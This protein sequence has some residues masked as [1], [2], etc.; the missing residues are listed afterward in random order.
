MSS[1]PFTTCVGATTSAT[2][3]GFPR[4]DVAGQRIRTTAVRGV[5]RTRAAHPTCRFP[6]VSA[7]DPFPVTESSNA[8]ILP[9]SAWKGRG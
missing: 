7:Q 8:K 5:P 2:Q 4:R 6:R 3:I 9:A 1:K